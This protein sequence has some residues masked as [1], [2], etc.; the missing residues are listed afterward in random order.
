MI[1]FAWREFPQY[2]ARCVGAYVKETDEEVVV[3]AT[4]PRVPISGMDELAGCKVFWIE[5]NDKRPIEMICGEVPRILI[6]SG[7]AT[8]CFNRFRDEVHSSGGRVIAMIDNN[9]RLS[10]KE[11]VRALRFRLMLRKRY[12]GFLV[13][14]A[15]GVRLMRFYGVDAANI[16]T[17][18]YVADARVFKSTSALKNRA[19]KVI[20]VGQLV[21]R[22]NV[23][24]MCEAFSNANDGSWTLELYGCGKLKNRLLEEYGTNANIKVF[25]FLQPEK[26]SV[27]YAESRVF[28]LPSREEHWGLVVH[29]AALSG[30]VL[31]LSDRVGAADDFLAE[32][33]GFRFS[34]Y[35]RKGMALCFKKA[36]T[37]SDS[38]L[39]IAQAESIM[40]SAKF[41]LSSFVNAIKRVVSA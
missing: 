3:V 35:D 11:C 29:E 4:S 8:E 41:R 5:I 10:F 22:K 13:P 23:I 6:V 30:C 31:L 19:K 1:C 18:M 17:G 9:F 15:S 36:M 2:A 25:D 14:G 32:H 16:S 33:N 39:D 24:N 34:P 40:Q 26:L 21:E 37:M 20:Y 12:D 7:W 28:C 27:K 38:D